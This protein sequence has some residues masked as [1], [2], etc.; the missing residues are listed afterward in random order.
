MIILYSLVFVCLQRTNL[1]LAVTLSFLSLK[2]KPQALVCLN[3]VRKSY[4]WENPW[5]PSKIQP[6][7]A[8]TS[9]PGLREIKHFALGYTTNLNRMAKSL[10]NSASATPANSL[11]CGTE[12]WHDKSLGKIWELV[13]LIAHSWAAYKMPWTLLPYVS[14]WAGWGRR[15]SGPHL[16]FSELLLPLLFHC[17][18]L[19]VLSLTLLLKF[20][21]SLLNLFLILKFGSFLFL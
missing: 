16:F 7:T 3:L 2:P 10:C 15:L 21:P 13:F 4:A 12:R 1:L 11:Y 8:K 14:C 20:S 19:L 17:S 9:K 18:P 6:L 5:K